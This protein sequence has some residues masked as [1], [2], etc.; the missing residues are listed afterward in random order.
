MINSSVF[1]FTHN[2]DYYE[3]FSTPVPIVIDQLAAEVT[4]GA[5]GNIRIGIYRSDRDFQPLGA[6][7]AD[8]GDLSA[9]AGAVKTYTPGTPITLQAGRYLG[10]LNLSVAAI[11]MRTYRCNPAATLS[12]MG[13]N[14]INL[15]H[16]ART[17]AAFPTPGTLWD[18]TDAS[19]NG[20]MQH[21]IV[22]RVLRP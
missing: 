5:A 14:P 4:T 2:R 7:L 13:A 20:T 6:P 12:T 8:S 21:T 19:V 18:T 17:Y 1:T 11:G 15:L 10:V 9:A 3:P 22:Y 16:V